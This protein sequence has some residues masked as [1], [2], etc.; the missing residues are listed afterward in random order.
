[1]LNLSDRKLVQAIAENPYLQ[2]FIGLSQMQM[3][4]PFQ[5]TALVYFRK[6]ITVD[7]INKENHGRRIRTG[8]EV[9]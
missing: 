1:M 5:A 8:I 2:Y 9:Y 7:F 6:R 3:E 4:C